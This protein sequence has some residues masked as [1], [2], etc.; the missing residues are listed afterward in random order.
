MRRRMITAVTTFSLLLLTG[1]GNSLFTKA[2]DQGRLAVA[3]QEYEKAKASFALALD[4]KE[5]KKVKYMLDQIEDMLAGRQAKEDN[6]LENALGYFEKVVNRKDVFPSIVEEARQEMKALKKIKIAQVEGQKKQETHEERMKAYDKKIET[7]QQVPD[8]YV[9]ANHIADFNQDGV[10]DLLVS[11]WLMAENHNNTDEYI[12]NII[13]TYE[14]GELVE[15]NNT[16]TTRLCDRYSGN[17][18]SVISSED[19]KEVLLYFSY[20]SG[21]G[22]I[23]EGYEEFYSLKDKG[24][25]KYV[26]RD[27]FSDAADTGEIGDIDKYYNAVGEPISEKDYDLSLLKYVRKTKLYGTEGSSY[28]PAIHAYT[29]Q[30]NQKSYTDFKSSDGMTMY[31]LEYTDRNPN[32]I[33]STERSYYD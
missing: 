22:G 27:F 7:L 21:K 30:Y 19:G 29:D 8:T 5:D 12:N 14:N 16:L 4:E 15:L 28:I 31:T 33:F 2:V 10:P 9:I 26:R 1:C 17:E 20:Y 11:T 25:E 13:Y 18:L 6:E 32:D 3:G 24:L 23:V